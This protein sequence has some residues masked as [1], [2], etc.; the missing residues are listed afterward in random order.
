MKS[1]TKVLLLT[2]LASFLWTSFAHAQ[3]TQW[4]YVPVGQQYTWGYTDLSPFYKSGS[5]QYAKKVQIIYTAAEL[6]ASGMPSGPGFTIQQI[7]FYNPSGG[8]YGGIPVTI[9]MQNYGPSS[10]SSANSMVTT[11][12]TTVLNGSITVTTGYMSIALSTPFAWDGV[13]NLLIEIC[14]YNG[15]S[16]YDY[17]YCYPAPQAYQC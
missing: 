8:T 10:W 4:T 3:T 11:G 5:A 7:C 17:A 6:K 1:F 15:N 9:Q 2:L 16:M 14:M 13:S 12:F